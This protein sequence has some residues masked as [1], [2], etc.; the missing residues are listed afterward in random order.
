MTRRND[1]SAAIA[2]ASA[3]VRAQTVVRLAAGTM[4]CAGAALDLC[5]LFL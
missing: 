1:A 2:A 3:A 5:R 4:I